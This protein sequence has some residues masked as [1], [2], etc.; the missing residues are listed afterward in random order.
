MRGTSPVRAHDRTS[1][2][3]CLGKRGDQIVNDRPWTRAPWLRPLVERQRSTLG[4]TI[5][6][7]SGLSSAS[8][9][10]PCAPPTN[11]PS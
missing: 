8:P 1:A 6:D 4:L 3:R 5:G 2:M 10:S 11:R 7:R 9:P